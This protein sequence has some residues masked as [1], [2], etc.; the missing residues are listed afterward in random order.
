LVSAATWNASAGRH[1][2]ESSRM[3]AEHVRDVAVEAFEID[4]REEVDELRRALE[5]EVAEIL[6]A[7]DGAQLTETMDNGSTAGVL[8]WENTWAALFAPAARRARGQLVATSRN[9]VLVILASL[10]AE[11]A[12]TPR[13]SPRPARS[14]KVQRPL[15]RHRRRSVAVDGPA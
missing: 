1:F 3:L 9:P 12:A 13:S 14:V 15:G 10:E 4:D 7:E 11:E 8:V 2:V 6:A 5:A